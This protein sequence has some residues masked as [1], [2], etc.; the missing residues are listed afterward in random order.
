MSALMDLLANLRRLDIKIELYEGVLKINAPKGALSDELKNNLKENKEAL[1]QFLSHARQS[2]T[3][4]QQKSIPKLSAEEKWQ[5]IPATDSQARFWFLDKFSPGQNSFNIPVPVEIQG[6][7]NVAYLEKSIQFLIERHDSLR[8][9]FEERDG[10]PYLKI[11]DKLEW[12]LDYQEIS[13]ENSEALEEKILQEAQKTLAA[14]IDLTQAP[15]L[16]IK[17]LKVDAA[18]QAANK[19]KKDRY[20]LLNCIHHIICDGWSTDIILR[21]MTAVYLAISQGMAPP[22]AELEIGFADYAAWMQ[23]ESNKQEQ[24]ELLDYWLAQLKAAKGI[25]AFPYD[26]ARG[27]KPPSRGTSFDFK[28]DERLS[29]QINS[30]CQEQTLTPFMFFMAAYQICLAKY[31]K[32]SDICV[33]IP[34]AGRTR[35]EMEGII[36][37]FLNALVIRNQVHPNVLL[38]EYLLAVKECIITAF[39]KQSLAVD[40]LI[41][42]LDIDREHDEVPGVQ[43]GFILQNAR[44]QQTQNK[45]AGFESERLSLRP[46]RFQGQSAK[47]DI[48]LSINEVAGQYFASIEYKTA[49]LDKKT[50]DTFAQH[51]EFIIQQMLKAAS[52]ERISN[53]NLYSK[54]KLCLQ[55][56]IDDKNC[57]AIKSLT[58]SQTG[59]YLNDLINTGNQS[60]LIGYSILIQGD[61]DIV[62]W[63]RVLQKLNDQRAVLRTQ[64]YSGT[65]KQHDTAYQVVLKN[66]LI[67]F[68]TIDGKHLSV[69]EALA[70]AKKIIYQPFV[71]KQS[72]LIRYRVIDLGNKHFVLI[73]SMHHILLD[74]VGGFQHW[75]EAQAIY[76]KGELAKEDNKDSYLAYLEFAS[77]TIDSASVLN[78]WRKKLDKVVA[79]DYSVHSSGN[80]EQGFHP[81]GQRRLRRLMV[82]GEQWQHIKQY[83]RSQGITPAILYKVVFG[84]LI[85]RYC[86]PENDFYINEIITG[87]PKE[88]AKTLGNCFLIQPFIFSTSDLAFE[89]RIENLFESAKQQQKETRAYGF[90]SQ[91]SL[92][93]F[94]PAG[95][96]G[97]FYN[98]LTF[99]PPG[100]FLNHP[101]DFRDWGNEI[102]QAVEFNPR[103][104]PKGLEL[105]LFYREALFREVD[106]LESVQYIVE[107]LIAGKQKIADLFFVK[108]PEEGA[109]LFQEALPEQRALDSKAVTVCDL[110]FLHSKMQPQQ[111]AVKMADNSL[112]YQELEQQANQVAHYLKQNNIQPKDIV[113]LA[114]EKSP[115]LLIYIL[116]VLK[117][118]A[119][120]LPLDIS[121]PE[122]RKKFII[123]NSQARL[124]LSAQDWTEIQKHSCEFVQEAIPVNNPAYTI[125]TSGSTG[126]PKGVQVSHRALIGTYYAWRDAFQLCKQDRH[127]QMASVGFDVFT[128]DWVRALCSGGSLH[129]LDKQGLLAPEKID[130]LIKSEGITFAEFVPVVLRGL[131]QYKYERKEKFSLRML[132]VG[133]DAWYESD[134]DLLNRCVEDGTLLVNSYGV[135]EAVIDSSF[136]MVK[137]GSQNKNLK[138]KTMSVSIGRPFAN[139]RL[140]VLDQKQHLLPKEVAGEL[141]I[142]GPDIADGYLNDDEKTRASYLPDLILPLDVDF[143]RSQSQTMA[144]QKRMYRTGDRAKL[145]ESGDLILLG[146][147]GQQVKIRGFRVELAEIE[148]QIS[149]LAEVEECVVL[150]LENELIQQKVLVAYVVF[151]ANSELSAREIRQKLSKVLPDYMLPQFVLPLNNFPVNANGKID[152]NVLPVADFS[153]NTLQDFVAPRNAVEEKLCLIWK[154]ILGI[155]KIGVHDNFFDLGG[156]SLLATQ[157]ASRIKAEFAREVAIKL[158]FEKPS[159][160]DLASEVESLLSREVDLQAPEIVSVVRQALMPVT[161][162]QR[163]FWFLDQLVPGYFAYNMPFAL[164]LQGEFDIAAFQ[165]TLTEIFRRHEILRC[166]FVRRN[167]NA[168]GQVKAKVSAA[169]EFPLEFI[170]L[171]TSIESTNQLLV[172]AQLDRMISLDAHRPFN[173]EKDILLRCTIIKIAEQD[174]LLSA[175]MHH[176]I[177]DGWSIRI[178]FQEIALIYNAFVQK[179]PSPLADLS[180]QYLDYASWE[181]SW[182]QGEVLDRYTQ[183]WLKQLEGA[184]ELLSLPTDKQRPPAQ[185]FNGKQIGIKKSLAFKQA[186]ENFSKKQNASV[187]MTLIA[188]MSV[189][190]SRYSAS[191]DILIGTPVAGRNQLATENLIGLFL[192]AVIIR[193]R[194]ENNPSVSELIAQLRETCLAAFAHQDMPAE[195]L[196][197]HLAKHRNPQ[198]PAGAQVGLVLQNTANQQ[199]QIK[200]NQFGDQLKNLRAELL[201]IEQVISNYDFGLTI[202]EQDDG[203]EI[204]AEFNTDLFFDNSIERMLQHYVLI[205]EYMFANPDMAVEHIPLVDDKELLDI[206]KLDKEVYSAVVP[207]TAMQRGMVLANKLNPL[208]KEYGVGFSVR[209]H[210]A[211]DLDLWTQSLQGLIDTQEV[212]RVSFIEN[213]IPYLDPVYQVIS[214]TKKAKVEYLDWSRLN[215]SEQEI[216]AFA[217]L[218]INAPY[219]VLKDDLMRVLLIK[220]SNDYYVGVFAAHHILLDGIAVV[221][222]GVMGALN[223]ELVHKGGNAIVHEDKYQQYLRTDRLQIDNSETRKFWKHLLQ[224]PDLNLEAL[225]YPTNSEALLDAKKSKKSLILEPQ[226][227]EAVKNYCKQQRITPALYF[228]GL[229]AMLLSRYCRTESDFFFYE[230]LAGRP[231]GHM[232]A[233]G[234]YFQQIPVVFYKENFTSEALVEDVFKALRNFQK[235]TKNKQQ[236]SVPLQNSLLPQ[237]ALSFMYNFENYIPDFYFMGEKVAIQEYSNQINGF[238]QLLVKTLLSTVELNLQAQEGFFED[239]ALLERMEALSK[240]IISG[241]N[242]IGELE[243]LN[244]QEK[245]QQLA[246]LKMLDV[247]TYKKSAWCMH[248]QFEQQVLRSPDAIAV[249]DA[250]GELSYQTL[251]EK[252][253]QLARYLIKLGVK[254][255]DVVG[256]CL[257]LCKEVP[258]ALLAILKCGASYLPMDTQYP[259]ER[260]QYFIQDAKPRLVL[261]L[262]HLFTRLSISEV[263]L[264]SVLD[265]KCLQFG[266]NN[267]DLAISVDHLIY[268]LYT[269]GS[270]GLPNCTASYHFN[271]YNLLSWYCQQFSMSPEDNVLII[272][273]LGFDLTQKNLMAPLTVGAQLV[274]QENEYFDAAEIVKTIDALGISWLNCAPSAFY[275]MI[276]NTGS[277]LQSLR[278][279]FL[280]GESIAFERIKS[281]YAD[282]ACYLVNSYGPS[283]CTDISAFYIVE[284]NFD[285]RNEKNIPIGRANTNVNLLIL[286][287]HRKLLPI[288]LPGELFIGGFGVGAGYINNASLSEKRFFNSNYCAGKIYKSGDIVKYLADGNIEYIGRKDFQVKLNGV[289]IELGEIEHKIKAHLIVKDAVVVLRKDLQH[290]DRLI[291]Y[292]ILRDKTQDQFLAIESIEQQL[293]LSLSSRLMPSVYVCLDS[294]PLSPNG[295]ID[296]KA[297]PEPQ[298]AVRSFV[299]PE[300]ETEKALASIWQQ[301][302]LIEKVSRYDNFFELGGSS[303][304]AV[305]LISKINQRFGSEFPLAIL[306]EAQSLDLLAMKLDAYGSKAWQALVTIQQQGHVNL[307]CIHPLGG[308][309][310]GYRDMAR[311]LGAE[312][313]VYGLQ[314][315]GLVNGQAIHDD[316]DTVISIYCEQIL[317]VQQKGPYHLCG[318]SLGGVLAIALAEALIAKGKDIAFVALFDSFVPSA[319]NLEMIGV[320]HLR[321]ALG[322]FMHIDDESLKHLSE[323]AQL[324]KLFEQAKANYLIPQDI[325]FSQIKNR[326]LVARANIQLA[327]GIHLQMKQEQLHFP[328]K[329][330]E[331][332]QSLSGL[333]SH[334]NWDVYGADIQYFKVHGHH[335]SIMQTPNIKQIANI[336]KGF[337]IPQANTIHIK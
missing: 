266:K 304:L 144:S 43:F 200:A 320:E 226:H 36:G 165:A 300:G 290:S 5:G 135:T 48:C 295:K 191:K 27:I 10:K 309:V 265:E 277:D 117:A 333:H 99:I 162:A 317:R 174:Y 186:L 185:T 33:G 251:N 163:R 335:E 176:I 285:Q 236:I 90:L 25:L 227:W 31:C 264:V 286:D 60:S 120:Y 61:F 11:H 51:F 15:L 331:A 103:L 4:G 7:L 205:L 101:V 19:S 244:Q 249:R 214:K 23:D 235:S 32:S 153:Q 34:I 287:Q 243:I 261:S 18:N 299:A 281:W 45:T 35:Q 242:K 253:N 6:V 291:A 296:R 263:L 327:Y 155:D 114:L 59:F 29:K 303:L 123:E 159:I 64:I 88:F 69:D 328:I 325:D 221:A 209:M 168:N 255:H 204:I 105:N 268:V 164:R 283:E 93:N 313:S 65:E 240:Q 213:D 216:E 275:P 167:D 252:A 301:I 308:E 66:H 336:L 319:D 282:S 82:E 20:I 100:D 72:P 112:S 199:N 187:F 329:H 272:S 83:C 254:E 258:L 28:M 122:D 178:L 128:G 109:C 230:I 73:T 267:L 121:I 46:I 84:F 207:L 130:F 332:E 189:L 8:T 245:E 169:T 79:P 111:L 148:N 70:E 91:Q 246:Y 134:Q 271:E 166:N 50:I 228:K 284:K 337:L 156:H 17:L 2:L 215:K 106:F 198:F 247:D 30:Y 201:G 63:Q 315:S 195:I 184:P 113:V 56:D 97:F 172:Q 292:V 293:R 316:L 89:S 259:D 326:Y 312:V 14:P 232:N 229:Y 190:M 180:I 218:F 278:W 78:F 107:Q 318:Q 179:R 52:S 210:Q 170:E 139:T 224:N 248:Q 306:F 136:S 53:L 142:G 154:T 42:N 152:R 95:R 257:P 211:M 86:Q 294:F 160:A 138:D 22:L 129:L 3:E 132:I 260:L 323:L 321:A 24:I 85:D 110:I 115:L 102:D 223:Y 146:R 238:V 233:L 237:S 94:S 212:A 161:Y 26:R 137:A 125:Y 57:E 177:S 127:L 279:V 96:V 104:G 202:I 234:C 141:Y 183:F 133:S 126:L 40:T 311:A 87:R 68:K 147:I 181:Q 197:E 219:N 182:L 330:F 98:Y 192:N 76:E 334:N 54:E 262:P 12:T 116:G 38:S 92:Q 1:I 119:Q 62:K 322:T 274:L 21:E 302:L 77:Y 143:V 44:E 58:P 310:I 206:L 67:D 231:A 175:C 270:T 49:L 55:L 217:S 256:I 203:M 13:A 81:H 108:E 220:I 145:C 149:L 16:R 289:R 222:F 194:L 171:N 239:Y 131:L 307:F 47:H 39:E 280:G 225:D 241:Q 250:R 75:V 41:D 305:Q 188:A 74:A 193:S 150:A 157:I 140:Y 298:Q 297:L 124:Q 118:G 196:Y 324:E 80:V 71:L 158:I 208:S 173:L 273:A 9:S 276:E 314:A 269:S 37:L 288:G 151:K